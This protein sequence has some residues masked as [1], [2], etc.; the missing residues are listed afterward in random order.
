MHFK[1][2]FL[3]LYYSLGINAKKCIKDGVVTINQK[4]M[5]E[6]PLDLT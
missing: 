6:K 5:G 4:N 1:L 2:A 3:L